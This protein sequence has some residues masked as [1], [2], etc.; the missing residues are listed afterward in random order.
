VTGGGTAP[1]GWTGWDAVLKSRASCF[2]PPEPVGPTD[3]ASIQYTSGT[4]GFPK[5]CMQSHRLWLV[6]GFNQQVMP[7]VFTTGSI[8]G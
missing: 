8:L 6:C 2:T 1:P 5:G 7:E 3:L 4:T